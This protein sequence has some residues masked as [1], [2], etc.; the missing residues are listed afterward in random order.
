MNH[1]NLEDACF[2]LSKTLAGV[3]CRLD[4]D[5]KPIIDRHGEEWELP[6]GLLTVI[7]DWWTKH[8]EVLQEKFEAEAEEQRIID[9]DYRRFY[10]ADPNE[11]YGVSNSDFISR[12]ACES[13]DSTRWY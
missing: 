5:G 8:I 13:A 7:G 4:D 11:D 9:E 12:E 10:A 1:E 3:E 6:A 2:W